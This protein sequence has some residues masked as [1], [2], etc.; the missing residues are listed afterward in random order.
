MSCVEGFYVSGKSPRR[1]KRMQSR[2][3]GKRVLLTGAS[4]GI[5]A[6]IARLVMQEGADVALSGTSGDKLEALRVQLEV[7][8]VRE[9][10]KLLCLPA[11]LAEDG[12]AQRL[13]DQ[14]SQQL[15][16]LDGL[17]NNAGITCDG[18]FM[19]MSDADIEKVLALNLVAAMRLTRAVVR[20]MMKQRA[21]SVV[22]ISSVVASMGNAGQC[23]YVASKA[24]LEGFS[25]ALARELGSRN[26][27]VNCVAPG[28]IETPMTKNL[29]D[30]QKDALLKSI[31]MGRMGQAE[32]IAQGVRFL[33][34]DEAAYVTGTTLHMNGGLYCH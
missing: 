34:S 23:N 3:Q 14:A 17:V 6:A 29:P 15:G 25:R 5:G 8:R 4:G 30:A 32:E 11:L 2:L 27:R 33:I 10:Q 24:G 9:D 7:L 12:E 20:G 22:N 13:G 18:L 19:R 26:V 31:P 28:F 16:G 21:G 1:G